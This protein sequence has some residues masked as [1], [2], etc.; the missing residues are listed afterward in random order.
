NGYSSPTQEQITDDLGLSVSQ[1]S[2]FG[3]LSNIGAMVGAIVSGQIADFI[4]RKGALIVAAIPNIIGRVTISFAKGCFIPVFGKVIDRLWSGCHLIHSACVHSRDSS[5]AL[6]WWPWS[7]KSVGIM[8]VYLC[9]L[10]LGSRALAIAGVVP[11]CLLF[12][13]L[14]FIPES[15]RWLAK[16]GNGD[17]EASLQYLRGSGVDVSLEAIEIKFV[18]QSAVEM[19]NQQPTI[20]FSEIFERRYAMPLTIGIGLLLLQQLSGI[21]GIMFYSSSIFKSA[22]I[23]SG[24]AATLGLGAVQVVMTAVTAGLIDR[25]GRRLLLMVSSGGLAVCLFLVGVAFHIKSHLSGDHHLEAFISV[26]TLASLLAYIISFSLGIGA[27]PWII[28]SEIL[29]VNVKGLAGSVAT[30]AN[31]SSSWLVTM[32]LNLLLQWSPAGTFFLYAII[33]FFTLIFV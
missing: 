22:G 5:Q 29:P 1:F 7:S 3:S 15:P 24:N 18:F 14:F 2:L 27:I 31:W 9:W 19:R 16:I 21:N 33:C 8:L 12:F 10:F 6:A 20:K 4:G 30:L 26:L 23:S 13:G 25:T 11:F 17:F 32:T 28:M